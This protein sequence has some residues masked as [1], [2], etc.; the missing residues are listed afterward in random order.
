MY[1][2]KTK[3]KKLVNEKYELHDEGNWYLT[4]FSF[5]CS[6]NMFKQKISSS[7]NIYKKKISWKNENLIQTIRF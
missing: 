4:H 2:F 5:P 7:K 3:F 6:V 1:Y